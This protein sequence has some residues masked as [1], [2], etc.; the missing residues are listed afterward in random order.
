MDSTATQG[1]RPDDPA[2]IGPYRL[3]GRL[4]EGGMGTVYLGSDEQG[5]LVAVKV[6]R[7]GLDGEGFAARFHAEVAG[8]RRVA[9]FCTARVLDDGTA[10]NGRPYMV[11]EYIPGTPLSRQVAT[12]GPL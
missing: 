4:G 11:T 12:H 6:V 10:E 2:H 3:L 1:L 5:R 8:A 9:S 7:Q